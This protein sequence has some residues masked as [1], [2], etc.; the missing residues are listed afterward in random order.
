VALHGACPA[1]QPAPTRCPAHIVG[2][3][4]AAVVETVATPEV[5]ARPKA[6]GS[7]PQASTP[8]GFADVPEADIGAWARVVAASGASAGRAR[9]PRQ[10]SGGG[11]L[12]S[13]A[14]LIVPPP[15]SE[16][17]TSSVVKLN[18]CH[19]SL[20]SLERDRPMPGLKEVGANCSTR[21]P[22]SG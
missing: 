18:A 14:S 3:R 19:W 2:K 4:H 7:G 9:A 17:P 8:Q 13:S 12:R 21:V 10:S 16:T 1:A 6:A 11:A 5:R 20:T 22:L 15:G